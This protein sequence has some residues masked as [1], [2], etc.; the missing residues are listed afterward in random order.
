MEK[1]KIKPKTEIKVFDEKVRIPK[2]IESKFKNKRIT[3]NNNIENNDENV[4]ISYANRKIE[5]YTNKVSQEI[6][7]EVNRIGIKNVKVTYNNM[8]SVKKLVNEKI[9]NRKI[10]NKSRLIKNNNLKIKNVSNNSYQKIKNR[11]SLDI[12]KGKVEN[13]NIIIRNIKNIN[14]KVIKISKNSIKYLFKSIKGIIAASKALIS[15]LLAGGWIGLIIIIVICMIGGLL[16]SIYGLFFNNEYESNYK[17]ISQ[18]V[19]EVN[20]EFIN[21]ITTIQNQNTYDEYDITGSR[22]DWKD[23]ISIFVAKHSKGNYE[24]E[25]IEIDNEDYKELKNVFWDMNNVDYNIEK[26]TKQVDGEKV[27]YRIL[28]IKIDNLNIDKAEKMYHFSNKQKDLVNE[29]LKDDYNALW[30]ELIYGTKGNTDIVE[31]ARSQIGNIGGQPYW[32]WY[33]FNSRVEWCACFVSWCA[34]QCGYIEAGIIPKF[35]GCD[36][37]GVGWFKACGLWQKRGYIPKSGDIIFFDWAIDKDGR[38]GKADHVGIVEK[39]DNGRVYT[40]EGNSSD[41]C[42][43]KSYNIDSIDILGYGTPNYK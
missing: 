2:G 37:E 20:T 27:T 41:S 40:I 7:P 18:I 26:T 11:K 17:N 12:V 16:S 25:M 35:A 42:K 43:E 33:G 24:T 13:K 21:K 14:D 36:T 31:V 28:H 34:N 29:L 22:T 8:K 6:I 15:L 23:V 32:S 10:E 4:E 3:S 1:I 39:V 9:S 38:N 30:S 5:H 19:S